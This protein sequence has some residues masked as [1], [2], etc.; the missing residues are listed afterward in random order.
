MLQEAV[1]A[2][3]T[4]PPTL[5]P[6]VD[7]AMCMGSGACVRACPEQALGIIDGHAML[8]N[9]T[10]C[11]GHGACAPACP[12]GAIKLVFGT[13]RRGVEI[14]EVS[15]EF[16]TNLP[17][18]F[19]AGELGGMGLIR[20]A[21]R[22]GVGA[23]AAVAKRPR[24]GSRYDVVIVGAGPAGIAASLAAEQAHLQY[25]TVE[26]EDQPGGTTR[27]YPRHKVVMTAPMKLP[28]I[29]AIDARELSK[30]DL[31]E[32]WE[33]IMDKVQP[34][35][36]FSERM[37]EIIPEDAGFTLR[38]SKSSYRAGSI[39]LAVGR[40][41]TPR[42]LGVPGEDLSKVVYRLS[43]SAQYRGLH[44]LVV[45]GGDSALEAALGI[46]AEPGTTVALSYRGSAFD[47]VK[48]KNRARLEQAVAAGALQ[49]LMESTVR[50][51]APNAV[52]LRQGERDIALRNDAVIICAGGELPTPM[53][54]KIGIKVEAHYGT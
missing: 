42:K 31:M 28:L 24:S 35:I 13:A 12:G 48:P 8:I 54:K 25:V 30:E 49:L 22:Q 38:T 14:P 36:H 20:N 3:L 21:I 47:R 11:I 44:V 18:I 39:L 45:G 1:A 19:I 10:L 53:L 52:M 6:V 23:I 17:G 26:Q 27:H 9:P 2:G 5:H 37:E 15:P 33:R 43:D 34:E 50:Q 46:A 4:E 7:L 51:I 40:H 16:E 32:I 41:G 29:D